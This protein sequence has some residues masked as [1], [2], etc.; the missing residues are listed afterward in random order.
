LGISKEYRII[1]TDTA[2]VIVNKELVE[3]LEKGIPVGWN[4]IQ[5]NSVQLWMNKIE[6]LKLPAISGCQ[7]DGIYS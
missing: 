4:V 1:D 3:K 5:E 7:Q 6:K 2:T